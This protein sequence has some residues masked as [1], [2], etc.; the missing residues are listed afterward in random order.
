MCGRSLG[1]NIVCQHVAEQ[2]LPG[3]GIGTAHRVQRF[4]RGCGHVQFRRAFQQRVQGI[5]QACVV[6]KQAAIDRR[7]AGAKRLGDLVRWQWFHR[8]QGRGQARLQA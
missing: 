3:F 4:P 7:H 5:G 2:P 8:R 1:G 6:G